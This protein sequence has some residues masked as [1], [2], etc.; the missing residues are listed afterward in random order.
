VCNG[1]TEHDVFLSYSRA[2]SAAAETLRSR[3]QDAGLNAFL[4]R[5]GLPAGQP[6]QP[7]LEDKIGSCRS[8]VALVG[9]SGFGERQ[10]RE[11][12]LGLDRQ[13]SAAKSDRPFPVIP[14]L[15]PG[16]AKEDVPAGRFL[17]LNTWVDLRRGLDETESFQRL[18]AGAQGHA[19]D[20]VAA[21]TV[22]GGLAP[23]RGLLPFRE[24][25]SGLF[26]G[27]ERFVAELQ[28]KIR[29]RTATNV[30]GV[31][32]RSGSGKSSI[33]Y[34]GLLPALRRERGV[35]NSSAWQMIDLRPHAE[36]LHQLALA[37][38]PPRNDLG[39]VD[40]RAELNRLAKRFRNREVTL[41][42]SSATGRGTSPAAPGSCSMSTSGRSFTPRPP[43]ASRRATRSG[44][45]PPTSS[46]SSTLSWTPPPPRRL[47]R[48]S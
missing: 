10:H 32:G 39:P 34:A 35:S 5:Y 6:W 31:I 13:A 24:Q 18:V 1:P 27:R 42:S 11:I 17:S 9:P 2:D 25:D 14:V 22:I 4:D 20:A 40:R 48:S 33:V 23:Y 30:V 37:F 29:R 19:I 47:V 12:Q 3:L 44:R 36:P 26:F 43:R 16:L 7:W 38:N 46:C 21:E 41:P 45:A 28:H 8:L 15:L